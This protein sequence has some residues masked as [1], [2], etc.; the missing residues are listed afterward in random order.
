MGENLVAI[1]AIDNKCFVTATI[2][3]KRISD[4]G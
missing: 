4:N 1:I 3:D 2:I